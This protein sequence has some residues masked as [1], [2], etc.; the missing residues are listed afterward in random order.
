MNCLNCQ[1]ANSDENRYCGKC[2]AELGRTLDETVRRKG[3]RDR[4]ATEMEITDAVSER[5]IR[6]AKWIGGGATLL[7]VL[8]GL[9]LGSTYHDIRSAVQLAKVDIQTTIQDGRQEVETARQDT[10]AVRQE[11]RA[12]KCSAPL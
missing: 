4:Q 10:A 9:L 11:T 12:A 1:T 5:L 3:F 6:W 8:F 2:G 7:V